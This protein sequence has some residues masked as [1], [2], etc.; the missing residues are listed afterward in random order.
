MHVQWDEQTHGQK[1]QCPLQQKLQCL[2]QKQNNDLP[3]MK[4]DTGNQQD[5]DN[6]FHLRSKCHQSAK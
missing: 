3:Q 6:R 5:R 4:F 2:I 1:L